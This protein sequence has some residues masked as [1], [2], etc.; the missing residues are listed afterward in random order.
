TPAWGTSI[1][2]EDRSKTPFGTPPPKVVEATEQ[3]AGIAASLFREKV[4]RAG[5][6]SAIQPDRLPSFGFEIASVEAAEPVPEPTA[7]APA[8][9]APGS[10]VVKC[11]PPRSKRQMGPTGKLLVRL[12]AVVCLVAFL[13]GSVVAFVPKEKLAD[14]KTKVVDWLEPGMVVLDYLPESLRPAK[15][16]GS[17]QRAM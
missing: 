4:E 1:P 3:E 10:N 5:A 12:L 14:W 6:D 16:G 8:A 17:F 11:A 9:P 2:W 15:P 13:G 7:V